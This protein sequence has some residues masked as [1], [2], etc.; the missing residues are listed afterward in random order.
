MTTKRGEEDEDI[1]MAAF[2]GAVVAAFESEP[3]V[4]EL[5]CEGL[6]QQSSSIIVLAIV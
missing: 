2:C 3:R 1:L 5:W 6:H 4:V